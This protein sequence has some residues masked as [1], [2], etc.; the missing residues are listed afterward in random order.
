MSPTL[1]PVPL[2]SARRLRWFTAILGLTLGAQ[3]G[4]SQPA[5]PPAPTV[6]EL[7][8]TEVSAWLRPVATLRLRAPMSGDF[9]FTATAG[10]VQAGD[11]IGRFDDKELQATVQTARL[12]LQIAR[13]AEADYVADQPSRLQEARRTISDLES[14][15]ALAQAVAKDPPLLASL[16]A[17]VRDSLKQTDP[18]VIEAQL[19]AAQ[20]KL[21][22]LEAPE[23]IATSTAHLQVLDA[24]QSLTAAEQ[25]LATAVV[26]APFAG[27]FQPATSLGT[28][29]R[30]VTIGAGQ[31]IGSLR[32]VTKIEAVV[33]A[34][35][36]Y[37]LRSS[38]AATSL[39]FTGPGGRT[40]VA[41]FTEART[42][43]S[44]VTGEGQVLVYTFPPNEAAALARLANTSSSATIILHSEQPVTL[45]S[46]LQAAL[47]HPEAFRSGWAAGVPKAWPGWTL[48]CE[49]ETQLGIA[50]AKP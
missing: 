35:S 30:A 37:L 17:G 9:Q 50:P 45:I 3:A 15:L 36:P 26:T 33:P 23:A 42:E 14:K 6:H 47:D 39:H 34:L 25:R 40:Y 31:E 27:L 29:D 38:L 41:T 22:R 19:T 21:T 16:P 28:P 8:L 13:Q 12:Q 18:A 11:T 49:G 4:R 20:A 24:G 2:H 7:V 5:V 44:P 1:A 32:D 10:P 46:K 43:T 48:V